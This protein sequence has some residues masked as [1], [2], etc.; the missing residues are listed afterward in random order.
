MLFDVALIGLV[1]ASLPICFMRPWIGS[2][3]WWWVSFMNPHQLAHSFAFDGWFAILIALATVAGAA[4]SP[5]RYPLP[6]SRERYL[7]MA[8]WG[9]CALTTTVAAINPWRAWVRLAIMSAI[10]VM[11]FVVTSLFQDRRKLRVLLWVTALSLGS[12]AL[13]GAVWVLWTGGVERLDGPMYSQIQNNNDLAAA[14]VGLAP[15]FVFLGA[16]ASQRWLRHVSLGVFGVMVVAILGTYSRAAFLALCVVLVLLACYRQWRAIAIACTAWAVFLL[17]TAPAK[18]V[19]RID[20]IRTYEADHSARLRPLSWYVAMR[21]GL[22]HPFFGAGFRPFNRDMYARYIPGYVDDH[23]AHNMFLQV[24]AE[25]GFPGL[26]LYTGLIASTLVTLWRTARRP[27]EPHAGW[28]RDYAQMLLV[29]LAGYLV[30]GTFHCLS[31]REV[32]FH[33]LALAMIVDTLARAPG[34]VV[35]RATRGSERMLALAVRDS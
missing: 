8:L 24:F 6:R 30:A 7:L 5:E 10:L 35:D 20:S 19:D 18:W 9:F 11:T 29:S 13:N 26:I 21:I 15:F 32:F 22:D 28:I 23:D 27:L 12:Y 25:H 2:L 4:V 1:V 34:H 3:L 14:L 16:S 31:Y 17:C 33:L